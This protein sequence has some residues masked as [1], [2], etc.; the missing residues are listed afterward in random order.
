MKNKT[1]IKNLE[2]EPRWHRQ[3]KRDW[4]DIRSQESHEVEVWGRSQNS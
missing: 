2:I 3:G 4:I 1:V